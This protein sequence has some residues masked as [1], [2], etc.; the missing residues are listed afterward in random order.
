MP[1]FIDH[2]KRSELPCLYT[3]ELCFESETEHGWYNLK[4]ERRGLIHCHRTERRAGIDLRTVCKCKTYSYPH[5]TVLCIVL[6]HI[7]LY[8]HYKKHNYQP[9]VPGEKKKEKTTTQTKDSMHTVLDNLSDHRGHAKWQKDWFFFSLSC[10]MKR[11][12]SFGSH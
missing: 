3:S 12:P 6:P 7:I 10:Y 2:R 4:H 1:L 11:H 9:L 5:T 8:M